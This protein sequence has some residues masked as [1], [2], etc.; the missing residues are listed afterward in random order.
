MLH[1]RF[2]IDSAGVDLSSNVTCCP[3][4]AEE[5]TLKI[6]A[7]TAGF[8]GGGGGGGLGLASSF[9]T[10]GLGGGGAAF[11]LTVLLSYLLRSPL[12]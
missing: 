1:A 9:F 6:T 8:A 4:Y 7:D 12:T 2:S 5:G 3:V 10:T 11:T